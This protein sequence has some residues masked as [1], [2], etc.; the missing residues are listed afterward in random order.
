MRGSPTES[1]SIS[2]CPASPAACA[3]PRSQAPAAAARRQSPASSGAAWDRAGRACWARSAQARPA[4]WRGTP[5]EG[6]LPE[7]LLAR[8]QHAGERIECAADNPPSSASTMTWK[9]SPAF[10][11]SPR[12]PDPNRMS[13]P[14]G[15]GFPAEARV[16]FSRLTLR[17]LSEARA[18]RR[19]RR[20]SR[21][22]AT[23]APRHE[24]ESVSEDSKKLP[25]VNHERRLAV[26][27]PQCRS[28]CSFSRGSCAGGRRPGSPVPPPEPVVSGAR[29]RRSRRARARRRRTRLWRRL[30]LCSLNRVGVLGVDER[31]SDPGDEQRRDAGHDDG[32]RGCDS[33]WRRH[34]SRTACRRLSWK[35]DM[36]RKFDMGRSFDGRSLLLGKRRWRGLVPADCAGNNSFAP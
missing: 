29:A 33:S 15:I 6:A 24:A 9:W 11:R 18:S 35:M 8:R 7:A 22:H 14:R 4:R 21:R 13:C 31:R 28:I 17:S 5:R 1:Q 25:A 20:P 3:A 19:V 23:R 27:V 30:M 16:D 32:E 2:I 12:C 36:S 26:G 34:S 10:S